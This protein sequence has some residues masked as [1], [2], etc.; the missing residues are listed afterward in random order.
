MLSQLFT[1]SVVLH[2]MDSMILIAY[3]TR[4]GLQVL[5]DRSSD[6]LFC[7]VTSLLFGCT[8]FCSWIQLSM[9]LSSVL[10]L[11]YKIHILLTSLPLA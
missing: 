9:L 6:L 5:P 10:L 1:M 8:E 3:T 4:V 2:K 7:L 11:L